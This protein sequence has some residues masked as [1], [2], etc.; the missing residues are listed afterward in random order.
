[1]AGPLARGHSCRLA[2]VNGR[3]RMHPVV[4]GYFPPH[5]AMEG[6]AMKR[7]P[8]TSSAIASVGY[9]DEARVLEVEFT[10]AEVYRYFDVDPDEVDEL[11]SAESRGAFL[12]EQIKPRHR[13]EHVTG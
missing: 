3:G 7:R 9:D 2:G 1:M 4:G 13:Y 11:M 10:S 6:V 5:P 8:V 12:N